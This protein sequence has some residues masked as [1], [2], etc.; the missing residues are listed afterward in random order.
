MTFTFLSRTTFSIFPSGD[1]SLILLLS[2]SRPPEIAPGDVC[3]C[4]SWLLC[5]RDVEFKCTRHNTRDNSLT[6]GL[7]CL[8]LMCMHSCVCFFT[9]NYRMF[10][11]GKFYVDIGMG[12]R[13]KEAHDGMLMCQEHRIWELGWLSLITH[14][15]V[16]D[17]N[18]SVCL[19]YFQGLPRPLPQPSLTHKVHDR[20][21]GN[22]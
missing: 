3:R 10:S 6:V 16:K 11:T 7:W 15:Q 19:S 8:D 4:L 14:F 17:N 20:V 21:K 2:K 12:A 9:D 1:P 18:F 5:I 22:T 13:W